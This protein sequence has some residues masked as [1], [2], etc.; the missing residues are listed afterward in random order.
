MSIYTSERPHSL[1]ADS[2][3]R[4]FFV[5]PYCK[6]KDV[7]DVGTGLGFGAKYLSDNGAA[8]VLGI[9]YSELSVEQ[10]KKLSQKGLSFKHI[11]AQDLSKLALKFDT[12]VLLEVLEHLPISDV[13][14]VIK[15]LV[16]LLRPQGHLI[17][18][19][20][21]GLK[22]RK[23]GDKLYN[24]YHVKEYL[25]DEVKKLLI[26][27]FAKLTFKGLDWKNNQ[28]VTAQNDIKKYWTYRLSV[29]LGHYKVIRELVGYIPKP[30]KHMVTHE[31]N[32]P[33]LSVSDF[34]L[35]ENYQK[36]DSLFIICRKE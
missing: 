22:S 3:A 25:P 24:P 34:F 36:C 12:I 27:H 13:P 8:K 29:L 7:L 6:G 15:S 31:G 10:A 18:T 16:N 20:P 28:L 23:I 21:N 33:Q 11:N 14:G 30:I 2:E 5:L 9:D 4:Y 26:P 17:T 32:L 1:S 19:T 35:S